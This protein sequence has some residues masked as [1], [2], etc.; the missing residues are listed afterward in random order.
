MREEQG[1]PIPL[2]EVRS[3][4]AAAP[5]GEGVLGGKWPC[6]SLF[7]TGPNLLKGQ[8][9]GWAWGGGVRELSLSALGSEL[10]A[11]PQAEGPSPLR[12]SMVSCLLTTMASH[13][14]YPHVR[15]PWGW[16][17]HLPCV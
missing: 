10:S 14:A 16:V 15:G 12:D 9:L 7:L 17:P 8:L 6:P 2:A 1:P 11:F 3:L 5:R 13:W 4:T